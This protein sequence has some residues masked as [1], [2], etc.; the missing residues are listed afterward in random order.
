MEEEED[1][2]GEVI[3]K[4][5]RVKGKEVESRARKDIMFQANR[6]KHIARI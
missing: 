1:E 5:G 6:R 4:G 3:R 2:A